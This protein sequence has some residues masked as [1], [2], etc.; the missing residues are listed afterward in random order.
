MGFNRRFNP[1]TLA[2]KQGVKRRKESACLTMT[3][4]AGDDPPDTWSQYPEAD[5]G[6][7]IREGSHLLDLLLHLIHV[8]STAEHAASVARGAPGTPTN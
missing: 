1:L 3:V 7:I 5:G 4:N 6:P 8:P 2:L